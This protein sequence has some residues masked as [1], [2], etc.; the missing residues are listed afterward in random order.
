MTTAKRIAI[1]VLCCL[2]AF[3]VYLRHGEG[4]VIAPSGPLTAIVVEDSSHRTPAIGAVLTDPTLLAFV[5]QNNVSWR[6]IDQAEAGPDLVDVQFALDGAKNCPLPAL[7]LRRG[8]GK[9]TVIALPGT[10]EA[11]LAVLKR[12]AG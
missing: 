3:G 9:P 11:C 4:P 5:A 10:A 2:F 8:A 7:V 12:Y 1:V 6:V